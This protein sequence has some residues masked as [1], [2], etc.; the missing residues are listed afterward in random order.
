MQMK[1]GFEGKG[2][3]LETKVFC[4]T[5]SSY[6]DGSYG[7]AGTGTAYPEK[8]FFFSLRT[9]VR[10]GAVLDDAQEPRRS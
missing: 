9:E 8:L 6:A 4:L 7:V 3:K 1:N 5:A 10:F 2:L